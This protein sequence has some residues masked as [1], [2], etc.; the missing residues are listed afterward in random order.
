MDLK[1]GDQVNIE[2]SENLQGK[3]SFSAQAIYVLPQT[4]N[5]D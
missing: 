3:D 4:L 1:K 5:R 2:S